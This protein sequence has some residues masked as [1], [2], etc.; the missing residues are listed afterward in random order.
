MLKIH[1]DER[2]YR[3]GDHG[4]KYFYRGPRMNAGAVL[5]R[6]GDHFEAH[7]HAIMEE[8]VYVV[9]GSVV[10]T[11][12]GTP[13]ELGPGDFFRIDPGEVH[14]LDNVGDV[15]C[16]YIISAAPFVAGDKILLEEP[17]PIVK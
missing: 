9:E 4:T 7:K 10:I 8:T 3:Y 13:Y 15:P 16:K 1:E 5:L 11:L 14:F 6:P 17:E 2:E 12:D